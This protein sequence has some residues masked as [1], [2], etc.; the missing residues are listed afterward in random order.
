MDEI[1]K[2]IPGFEGKYMASS[3]GRIMSLNFRGVSGRKTILKQSMDR[4]GYPKCSLYRNGKQMYFT[5]HRLVLS[6]FS[7]NVEEK[8]EINHINGDKS[9]NHIGNLEWVTCSENMRHAYRNGLISKTSEKKRES[10]RKN[11]KIAIASNIG[12]KASAE[13]RKKMSETRKGKRHSAEWVAHWK[14]SRRGKGEQ[15]EI[16]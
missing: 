13:T 7:P 1:W 11:I 9:D 10:S 3:F 14:E 2:E 15:K 4:Y 5:V 16:S 12:R 6:A 8:P